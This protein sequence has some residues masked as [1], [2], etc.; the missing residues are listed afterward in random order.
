[1]ADVLNV[2]SMVKDIDLSSAI[3]NIPGISGLVTVG[4]AIGVVVLIYVIFLIV[5]TIGQIS[6]TFRFRKLTKNVD[7]IN[8]KMDVLIGKR[9]KFGKDKEEKK[10]K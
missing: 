3:A 10:K 2:S 5:R 9:R 8:Q 6:Y 7:E 1:M 4:K